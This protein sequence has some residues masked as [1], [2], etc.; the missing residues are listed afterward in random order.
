MSIDKSEEIFSEKQPNLPKSW[1]W[2]KL[3]DLSDLTSGKAFKANEYSSS[4]IRLFQIANVSFGEIT[5]EKKVYL[6]EDFAQKYPELLLKPGDI[7]LAL[8]RPIL[9]GV[10]KVG[11]LHEQDTPSILYQRVGRFDFYFPSFNSYLYL[12]FRSPR[13]VDLLKHSLQGVDQ[14]FINKPQLMKIPVPIAPSNEQ[15][16]IVAKV[17]EL[18]SFL[19]AGVGSLRVVQAQLKRY[20]QAVL[21][22]AFEG[23]LTEEWR[24]QNKDKIEPAQ[25]LMERLAPL[26]SLRRHPKVQDIEAVTAPNLPDGWTNGRLENLI[27]IAGRIGWRGLKAEEYTPQGPLFLS[28]YNLNRGDTVD[29]SESY[30][31]SEERYT[32]SPEIQL[33]N[34]DILLAK[35]GAGIGKIGIVQGL[36]T[37]ATV[38]SSLLVIRS[39]QVFLPK[40]LFY[41]LKGPKMQEL[42]KSRITG[43]ATPHLFQRDIRKFDLLIPPILEQEEII[44]QVESKLSIA[45]EVEKISRACLKQ[46][47]LLRQT[48]LKSA[49]EG[50]LVPQDPND[51]PAE[52]LLERIKT[53]RLTNK[54]KNQLELSKYV[55]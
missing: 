34:E 43:S 31:I 54:S 52:N 7:V 22:A 35:D 8:N 30:H 21:K 29:L 13:F 24:Q 45:D 32:E 10:L 40:F 18:L 38:N 2:A 20:R 26:L 23:K 46:G 9:D 28:V 19:A 16:R 33:R 17:E 47:N 3:G 50:K 14:P 42:V 4:G 41:F 49:F 25:K 44:Q 15:G 39:G 6:P 55:K 1:M 11:K 5:W 37:K 53:E 12:Y 48:V 36:A 27:Y 51:E